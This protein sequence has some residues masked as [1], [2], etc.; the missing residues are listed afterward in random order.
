MNTVNAANT[1]APL[2]AHR[3]TL[4][5]RL[6]TIS[7]AFQRGVAPVMAESETVGCQLCCG[8]STT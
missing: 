1:P 6:R 7:S 5:A 3:K 4:S 8:G 2:I